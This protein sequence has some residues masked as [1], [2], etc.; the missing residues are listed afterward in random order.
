MIKTN[1]EV[2]AFLKTN[3]F[4]I[5]LDILWQNP[6][7]WCWQIAKLKFLVIE[8][9]LLQADQVRFKDYQ[10]HQFENNVPKL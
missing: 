7:I 2:S 1:S 3:Q 5:K 10:Q 4:M 9:L 6:K 8:M